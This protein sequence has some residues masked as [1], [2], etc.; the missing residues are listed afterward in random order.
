V[1][2]G[3]DGGLESARRRK[4]WVPLLRVAAIVVVALTTGLLFIPRHDA[5][6]TGGGHKTGIAQ[7]H[8]PAVKQPQP[9]IIEPVGQTQS[10]IQSEEPVKKV[11]TRS[12]TNTLAQND[13]AKK[14]ITP[15]ANTQPQNVAIEMPGADNMHE[16]PAIAN[17]SPK[18]EIVNP[19]VPGKE[20]P[21]AV[22]EPENSI[23]N[24]TAST[25]PV[26]TAQVSA[27]DQP[28]KP[29]RRG[30]HSFG[31]LVSLVANKVE[32]QR[33]ASSMDDDD[34]DSAIAKVNRGIQRIRADKE[35]EK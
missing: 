2:T 12:E 1:W 26:V 17:A 7:V 19:V 25:K 3:I 23:T 6:T 16:Q 22:K 13:V 31:D 8:T 20:T 15:V 32:K 11:V 9:L 33:A 28:A 4:I 34:D 24:A 27:S 10:A 35:Q 30:I 5:I 14:D 29:K 18:V 21:L